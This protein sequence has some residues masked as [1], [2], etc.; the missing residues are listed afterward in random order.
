MEM[1]IVLVIIIFVLLAIHCYNINKYTHASTEPF[2]VPEIG[3]A[4]RPH[5]LEDPLFRDVKT[6]NNDENPYGPG[7]RNG[8]EKCLDECPGRCVEFGVTGLAFCF[9]KET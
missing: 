5:M 8:L 7:Q 9:P 6:F 2:D 3:Y 4:K 1:K